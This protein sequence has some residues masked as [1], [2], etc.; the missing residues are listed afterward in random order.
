MNGD[1]SDLS[2][3]ELFRLE[4]ETQT[5]ILNSGLVELETDPSKARLEGLMRAAHSLKGAARIC[6][7]ETAVHLAHEM[8]SVLVACLESRL[9]LTPQHIDSLL[10]GV[11]WLNQISRQSE[12]SVELF[13]KSIQAEVDSVIS[14]LS[15]LLDPSS[16]VSV[17]P[18]PAKENNPTSVLASVS[19]SAA[20][21]PEPSAGFPPTTKSESSLPHPTPSHQAA[22]KTPVPAPS[23]PTPPDAMETMDSSVRIS[24]ANLKRLME[25]ASESI[26]ESRHLA[27]FANS[28]RT[29]Q[30]HHRDIRKMVDDFC[31]PGNANGPTHDKTSSWHAEIRHRLDQT[32]EFLTRQ[33]E[34]FDRLVQ[35]GMTLAD[36]LHHGLVAS[37]MR[38]ISEGIQGFS[39]LVRDTSRAL[40]KKARLNVIGENTM[41]DRDLLEKL[42]A[43]LAH[44]LRNS[45]DHGLESPAERLASGK[46]E[47][48]R[49]RL[50]A[51]HSGGMLHVV[52]A[53]D[54][55]GIDCQRLKS[56]VVSR[57]LCTAEVAAGLSEDEVLSFLFLP[58]FSTAEKVTEISGR[59][60]GLDVVQTM[61]QEAG[62]TLQ[63]TTELGRGTAIH[64]Q[65]PI[66]RSV[67]RALLM[68]IAGE[69]FALPLAR[70]HRALKLRRDTLQYLEGR[71]FL[72]LEQANIGIVRGSEVLDL[73][74]I[75]AVDAADE[76]SAVVIRDAHQHYGFEV[77]RFIGEC[78]LVVRPIDSRLGKTRDISAVALLDDHSPV[79]ILD[80]DDLLRSIESHL[81][82]GELRPKLPEAPSA[83]HHVAKRI[84]VAE[85][86]ITVRELERKL[87]TRAGYEVHVAI[88]GMEAWN[89]LLSMPVDLL[90]TDID[91]PRLT[92]LQLI[93]RV[94]Q[95][96][97]L[98][99]L[100]VIV[101][102]Y[103]DRAEDQMRG[104]EAGAN[105]Y[106]T[107]S[108]FRDESFL[109]TV[110]DAI[111]KLPA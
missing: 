23:R 28:L 82:R 89:L 7:L 25:L 51:R 11:D 77:D 105:Y 59:G 37:R 26:L 35:R 50:E 3:M 36:R 103:K 8:E 73:P 100:P 84:L 97:K 92:G 85:D 88:D 80:P 94:R 61:V 6:N 34:D 74:S 56:Q 10:Q 58:G 64:L 63:V 24:A 70:I 52:I 44:M 101:M 108:S 21:S 96:P 104:L 14:A 18:S 87:L 76:F 106:L 48:G 45:V 95:S 38:P 40:G 49:V 46:S 55:R 86:S 53:D 57:Q 110:W 66:S 19:E 90:I 67:L 16:V 98:A 78:E 2:M 5:G 9:Q 12:A 4:A 107:K 41:V 32:D 20:V 39:R 15:R 47:E 102:S 69:T 54:G 91:M 22:K 68:E 71:P 60:V 93:T 81:R 79:L 13:Q 62:G 111:E 42:E 65:L 33:Q 30:K 17:G 29:L 27:P 43:P 75:S 1:L 72:A 99:R 83:S 31:M 109:Q